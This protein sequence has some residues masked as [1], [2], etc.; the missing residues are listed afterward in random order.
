MLGRFVAGVLAALLL[1][2]CSNA[3][4]GAPVPV[5]AAEADRRLVQE[6]FDALNNAA[7]QGPTAQGEFLGRTQHPD[8]VGR[9]CDLGDFTVHA[10]PAM[11]TLRADPQ[12]APE[13]AD[14]QP[15]GTVY[16]VSVALTVRRATVSVGEQIGSQRVVVLDGTAYGFAPCLAG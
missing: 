11:S 1:V 10:D 3:M 9:R 13:N 15:R 16:V 4:V 2:G 5:D 14:R 8:F 12:W 7:G 6:Y